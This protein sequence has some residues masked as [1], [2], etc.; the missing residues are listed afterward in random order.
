MAYENDVYGR[1]SIQLLDHLASQLAALKSKAENSRE[2]YRNQLRA[3]AASGF[4]TDYTNVL[5]GDKYNS[6]SRHI[7]GLL[8]IVD[9]SHRE[10]V[11]HKK[12]IEQLAEDA[13]RR[14]QQ[15]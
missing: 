13:R 1:H 4:M 8:E 9:I 12:I 10:M 7:D 15:T 6:F 5:G 14:A 11:E 2:S 3:A